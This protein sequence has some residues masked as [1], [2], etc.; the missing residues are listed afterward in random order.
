MAAN[1]VAQGRSDEAPDATSTPDRVQE[2]I[3][4][5]AGTDPA[6]GH[7]APAVETAPAADAAPQA[8]GPT[9][10]TGTET[11]STPAKTPD[12][13]EAPA[14][15][16]APPADQTPEFSQANDRMAALV[17]QLE[18]SDGRAAKAEEERDQRTKDHRE[19]TRWGQAN[20]KEARDANQ[21]LEEERSSRLEL[22]QR[23][24][25]EEADKLELQRRVAALEGQATDPYGYADA[26]DNPPAAPQAASLDQDPTVVA[27]QQK[28]QELAE[29]VEALAKRD[30]Q[31]AFDERVST[32]TAQFTQRKAILMGPQFGMSEREAN[33]AVKAHAN[34]NGDAFT[35]MCVNASRRSMASR[36]ESRA[37]AANDPNVA[38]EGESAAARSTSAPRRPNAPPLDVPAL[39]AEQLEGKRDRK[40]VV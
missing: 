39:S 1:D 5:I 29:T 23:L 24:Q 11:D 12:D 37:A 27:L 28:N 16:D 35:D 31:R 8:Q 26:L 34:G 15:D 22:E 32:L 25:R 38:I 14:A 30:E 2:M 10:G 4:S 19:A 9:G 36:E 13:I 20:L 17:Q 6:E 3:A 7:S 40:S 18:S 21:Q 33:A